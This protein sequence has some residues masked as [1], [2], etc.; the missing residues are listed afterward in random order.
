MKHHVTVQQVVD[1]FAGVKKLPSILP[2][3]WRI[4]VYESY[5]YNKTQEAV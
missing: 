1:H 4:A 5:I 3:C 2:G